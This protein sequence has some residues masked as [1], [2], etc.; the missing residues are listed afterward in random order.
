MDWSCLAWAG[1]GFVA[2]LAFAGG[3]SRTRAPAEPIVCHC[4]CASSLPSESGASGLRDWGLLLLVLLVLVGVFANVVLVL[5][6]DIKKL[7][8]GDQE[9]TLS[10][11]GKSASKGV[12]GARKGLELI[13][14]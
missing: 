8:T 2:A 9:Y 12:Y 3:S 13:G 1:A 5:R 7:A 6:F 14:Q 4:N 11:K 10:I